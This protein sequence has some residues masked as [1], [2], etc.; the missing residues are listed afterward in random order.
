MIVQVALRKPVENKCEARDLD[1]AV[2]S[3]IGLLEGISKLSLLASQGRLE[4]GDDALG[5]AEGELG[6]DEL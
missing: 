4:L 2:T 1:P 5:V 6:G 3:N